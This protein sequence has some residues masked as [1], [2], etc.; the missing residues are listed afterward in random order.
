MASSRMHDSVGSRWHTAL[1]GI[2]GQ[3]NS[4]QNWQNSPGMW[5]SLLSTTT[6]G[7]WSSSNSIVQWCLGSAHEAARPPEVPSVARQIEL[8][9]KPFLECAAAQGCAVIVMLNY[10]G[11]T[12]HLVNLLGFDADEEGIVGVR[13]LGCERK[14]ARQVV[15]ISCSLCLSGFA[16]RG[17]LTKQSRSSAS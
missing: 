10:N 3:A 12:G 4:L 11:G 7:R 5:A 1:P 2:D 8:L 16:I 6:S 14:D 15:A 17:G 9:Q 13:R